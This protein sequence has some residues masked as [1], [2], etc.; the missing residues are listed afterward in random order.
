MAAASHVATVKSSVPFCHFFDGFRTSH[1]I[2]AIKFPTDDELRSLMDFEAIAKY[3]VRGL[4]PEHPVQRGSAQNPD[5]F[6]QASEAN[7]I[8]YSKVPAIVEQIFVS[9]N[10]T[11]GTNY[12][13]FEYIGHPQAENVIV[14]MGSAKEVVKSTV[15][16]LN[17]KGEKVGMIN[18]RLYRPFSVSHFLAAIPKTAKRICVL[19]RGKDPLSVDDPLHADIASAL[20]EPGSTFRPE[21]LI[22]GRYGL[23]SKDFNPDMVL[24][25]YKNLISKSPKNHFTV[26]INDDVMHTSLDVTEHIN[27]LPE[28]TRQCL[29][30]GIGGDGTIGANK[31]AIKLIADHTELHSQGYFSYDAFKSG[32]LTLSHLRF[33]PTV[34]EAPYLVSAHADYV[35][36]HNQT[37]VNRFPNLVSALKQEGTF[38]LN[39]PWTTLE[40]L[41]NNLP[42]KLRKSIAEKKAAFYVIDASKIARDCSIGP[43]INM[44]LQ[45]VFFYLSNVLPVKEALELL[46]GSIK[47]MYSKKGDAIVQQ[48]IAAVDKSLDPAALIKVAY[49]EKAWLALKEEPLVNKGVLTVPQD[50]KDFDEDIFKPVAANLGDDIPVSKMPIGGELP[51]GT[52][53][54]SKRGIA[55]SIPHW[56]EDSCIQCNFCSFVCPHAVIRAY[57]LNEEEMKNA[58]ENFTTIKSRKSGYDFRINVSA[59]DCT[60][61]AVCAETCPKKCLEMV[62]L[63][64]EYE[65]TK[66]AIKFLREE[67]KQKPELGDKKTV[68]GMAANQPLL[69]FPGSCAGCG[70]TPLVRLLTQ[71]FGDRMVIAAATGCNS[72][73]GGSFPL[74]PYSKSSL[75]GRGPAWHNSLFEDGA[76]LGYGMISGYR[77]RRTLLITRVQEAIAASPKG[78]TE[79]LK[80]LLTEWH[81][82]CMDFEKSRTLADKL[83]PVLKALPADVDEKLKE[84]AKPYNLELYARTSFWIIG[85][86]GWA[87]DIDY[88]GLDHVIANQEDINIL[89]LDTE[90]Y[91][92]TGGQRSKATPL[93]AQAKFAVDGKETAKKDL[94]RMAMSYETAY[95]ASIAQGADMQQCINAL[96]EAENFNGPSLVI[97]YTPCTEHHLIKGMKECMKVQKLAVETGYWVLYRFNPDL[98]IDGKNPFL[99]D[100]KAPAKDPKEFLS[101]QG[102]FVQLER[103]NPEHAKALQVGL[104]KFLTTRYTRYS[105]MGNL[106]APAEVPT[107]ATQPK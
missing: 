13:L 89:V 101:T 102:R 79:D 28:G 24:A 16:Y 15:E 33:G 76:E 62:P 26:G 70:E 84:I 17:K 10:K 38:V 67:V 1:E 94:G 21:V 49:D 64:P 95:V 72:I 100:S 86:D 5:V 82:I 8:F 96:R 43:Y 81:S 34:F 44:V 59:L 20:L 90:V 53:Q 54:L 65:K 35:A 45:A 23:S 61:C 69:E 60:G 98:L 104:A 37:Y 11:F 27:T 4:N 40:E 18:I 85:G 92:N 71:M 97:A 99:L 52:S 48:N 51:T 91:S 29:L 58:P 74:V 77:A 7:S 63:E 46:K 19:D 22:G 88:G 14:V 25:V 55:E 39:C 2:Q 56:H 47:K 3:R 30:W 78:M 50:I 42:A 73:W 36:C 107:S 9:V 75:T 68:G 6:F 66:E 80:A 103:E 106:Y 41:N 32:G 31:T 83:V 12:K 57:Q 87:Y 93:A 105:R